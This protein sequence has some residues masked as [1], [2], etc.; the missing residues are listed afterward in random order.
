MTHGT[1]EGKRE[2]KRKREDW[3]GWGV[4]KKK[5]EKQRQ[6]EREQDRE[7]KVFVNTEHESLPSLFEVCTLL[8]LS[9]TPKDIPVFLQPDE[10]V[11]LS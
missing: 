9:Y 4:D 1:Q 5:R 10:I 7:A 6:E 2:R 8:F 3:R 11:T